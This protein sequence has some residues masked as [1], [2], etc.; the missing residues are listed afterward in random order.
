MKF[1]ERSLVKQLKK[2]FCLFVNSFVHPLVT[3]RAKSHASCM[4]QVCFRYDSSMIQVSFKSRL[5][6]W[7]NGLVRG[8]VRG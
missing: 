2:W 3:L 6:G 4:L 7:G 1:L 5:K 8:S